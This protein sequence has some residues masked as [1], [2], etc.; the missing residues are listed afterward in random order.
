MIKKWD[1]W[2]FFRKNPHLARDMAIL[3]IFF[4]KRGKLHHVFCNSFRVKWGAW[5][6]KFFFPKKKF[7]NYI[8]DREGFF[9]KKNFENR[10]VGHQKKSMG[11]LVAPIMIRGPPGGGLRRLRRQWIYYYKLRSYSKEIRAQ[12]PPPYCTSPP[13]VR[14]LGGVQQ[15]GAW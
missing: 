9:R 1:W 8:R 6:R 13:D 2:N 12:R 5:V 11:T 10:F 7:P 3:V 14:F 15:G 4:T